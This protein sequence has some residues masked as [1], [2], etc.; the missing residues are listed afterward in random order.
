[1]TRTRSNSNS[2]LD[3]KSLSAEGQIIVALVTAHFDKVMKEKDEK[4]ENLEAT[5]NTLK[6]KINSFE[7][8]MD[9]NSAYSRRD[10]L[11]ISGNNLPIMNP[12]ENCSEIVRS[13]LK[14]QIRLVIKPDDIST[15]HRLGRRP[16]N[17]QK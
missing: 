5:V 9:D 1:M 14:D 11:V 10:T 6:D 17:V 12:N 2:D 15:A 13:L 3:V 4:I 7:Q 8:Q 16:E